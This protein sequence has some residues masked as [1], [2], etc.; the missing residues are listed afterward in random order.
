MIGT[1]IM[2]SVTQFLLGASVAG[3][4]LG[5][6]LG[7]RALLIGG[8]IGTLPDLDAFIP[9]G[10]AID[11]MT[12][13]RGFSHS[14]LVQTAVAPLVAYGVTRIVRDARPHWRYVLLAAWLC[15]ITHSLLDAL[16]TY[17]TQILWPL[18]IGPP[19]ALPSVFIIDPLFTS[20]LLAGVV[21]MWALRRRRAVAMRANRIL[22]LLGMLYLGIGI[23]G[24]MIVT[25]RAEAHPDFQGKALHV[26]PAPF[27]ILF[28]QVL[29]VDDRRYV[30]GLTSLLGSCSIAEISSHIR[31]AQPPNGFVPS[32]SVR[33]LEWFSDGF[34]TYQDNTD[35][36]AITDLRMGLHPNFVF[37]FVFARKETGG[38][39]AIEPVRVTL[40]A[41]RTAL[42]QSIIERASA[43]I[44]AC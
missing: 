32:A 17:G 15:L 41:P 4:T 30:S 1:P 38:D 33:R 27:N 22:L 36:L 10:N 44:G 6:R 9:M 19:V 40:T 12:H 35:G 3:A 26:Q 37:S 7:A 23:S 24:H 8:V 34:Y 42:V 39:V 28:W 18:Q 21:S 25:A 20:L 43:S 16:T 31:H 13:H 11:T 14:V 5:P 29:G 2:D